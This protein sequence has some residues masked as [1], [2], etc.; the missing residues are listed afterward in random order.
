M[1]ALKEN[2]QRAQNQQKIYA[3]RQCTEWTFEVGDLVFLRLQPYRQSSMMG[4]GAK[5][6]KPRF[7]GRYLVIKKVGQVAYKL[8]L[9]PNSRNHN[10]FHVSC[11]KKALGQQITPTLE[12]PPLDYEGKL[13]LKPETVLNVR[14]KRLKDKVI[15][16]YLVKWKGLP[17]EDATWE[18]I[19]IFEHPN[20]QLLEVKQFEMEGLS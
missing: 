12:L 17:P 9:P 6:L 20:L 13:I 8:E 2:L 10:I 15:T 7:Y 11:L 5:K 18:G 19:E 16:E 14:E 4:N 1:E 3:D